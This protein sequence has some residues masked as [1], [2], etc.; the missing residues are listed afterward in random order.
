VSS[1]PRRFGFRRARPTKLPTDRDWERSDLL[2]AQPASRLP[3]L[4]SDGAGLAFTT[5]VL[6]SP[7]P[8]L[9]A[10]DPAAAG[11][12][13][14]LR[15][16]ALRGPR[17]APPPSLDGWRALTRADDEAL[18][19]LGRPAQLVT[20]SMRLDPKRRTWSAASASQG[21]PLR[22]VRDGIRASAWRA[23]PTQTIE[24]DET[25]L[26]VL[27]TEQTFA[28]GQP[29]RGRVLTPDVF[30][31]EDELVMRIYVTPR[32]GFQAGARNPETPVRIA[33]PEP[34]GARRLLDGALLVS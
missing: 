4:V 18:F 5:A 3:E 16:L 34:I 28:F 32:P 31:G 25:V 22:A 8:P 11:L 1:A 6:A 17:G 2:D 27:V 12:L 7:A 14:H 26:R 9:D 29:A 13:A 24:P 30:L 21:R 19:G 20:V 15:Q 23:D 33:L 10:D